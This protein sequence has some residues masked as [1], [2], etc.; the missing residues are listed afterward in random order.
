MR[1]G[2]TNGPITIRQAIRE[3]RNIP[4]IRAMLAYGGIAKMIQMASRLGVET[5]FG[6][7]EQGPSLAIGTHSV[8]LTDMTA[9]YSTISNLGLRGITQHKILRIQRPDGTA[10]LPLVSAVHAV[11]ARLAWTFLDILKDNANKNASWLTGAIADLGRPA[12]V[13]TPAPRRTSETPTPSAWS[14]SSHGRRVGRQHRRL[15]D[16]ADVPLVQRAA[17]DRH[18]YMS[19]FVLSGAAG[20]IYEVVWARQL[21]L[22]FGNTSQAVSTILTGFFGGLAIGGV[23]RRARGGPGRAAAAAVR[24]PRAGVVAVVLLTPVSFRLIGEAYRGVYPALA[25][26]PLALALVR[27]ALAILALAPAT[28]AHGRHAA[29]A[30]PVPDAGR[31][32]PR[33]GV[34]AAVHR[35]H[36]RR[37]RRDGARRVRADRA[38]GADRGARVGAVCSGRPARSPW[39]WT[40]GR[41]S[42]T[43]PDRSGARAGR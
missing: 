7:T 8:T 17:R 22:V 1:D 35:Q 9:V 38:A 2:S 29:D 14:R 28:P 27:F 12:A 40:G 23:G 6:P 11:D 30:H 19:V 3:S 25:G 16:G 36:D 24:R 43:V 31:P 18:T 42:A 26:A 39:C 21:V 5:P 34:P 15:A 10:V 33:R 4:A 41:R 37:D 13:K 32:R 20:L